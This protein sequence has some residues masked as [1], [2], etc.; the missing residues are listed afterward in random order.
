M[1]PSAVSPDRIRRFFSFIRVADN[2]CWEWTGCRTP[3][4]YGRFCYP[5][6]RDYNYAHRFAIEVL[7]GTPIPKSMESDH[8]CRNPPCA[9]PDHLEVV[10]PLENYMRAPKHI[11]HGDFRRWTDRT[12]DVEGCER[13]H[14]AQGM[15]HKHYKVWRRRWLDS[16]QYPDEVFVMDRGES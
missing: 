3:D 16:G 7:K 12:C 10:T 11:V 9:N 13:K 1:D 8:L 6:G 4:G 2:G 5:T 14:S 15:C